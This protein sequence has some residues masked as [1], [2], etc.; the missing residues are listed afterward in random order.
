MKIYH[1]QVNH[2]GKSGGISDGTDGLFV[3]NKRS[4]RKAAELCK[5]PCIIG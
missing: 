5:D 1:A 2:L 4:E 3:E